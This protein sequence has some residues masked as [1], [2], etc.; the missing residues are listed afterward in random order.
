MICSKCGE[1][2]LNLLKEMCKKCYHKKY[3]LENKEKYMKKCSKCGHHTAKLFESSMCNA[4]YIDTKDGYIHMMFSN[5]LGRAKKYKRTVDMDYEWFKSFVIFKTPFWAIYFR[6]KDEGRR[7]KY[8][9]SLDRIDNDRGYLKDNIQ[10]ISASENSKKAH[11]DGAIIYRTVFVRSEVFEGILGYTN[12]FESIKEAA[13]H[14]NK[15][16]TWVVSRLYNKLKKPDTKHIFTVITKEEYDR[17]TNRDS[18]AART[19]SECN[20]I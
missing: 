4:C 2:C 17:G 16:V 14:F 19:V 15:S 3:Y 1:K 12:Y 7:R 13:A 5:M 18:R 6:W 9:P 8:A 20:T 10:V 11:T